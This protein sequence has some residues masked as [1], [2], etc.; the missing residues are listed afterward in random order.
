MSRIVDAVNAPFAPV[1]AYFR[2]H[3]SFGI[4]VGV[5]LLSIA[6]PLLTRVPPFDGI[7]S[8]NAWVNA[9]TTAAIYAMLAMGLNVVIGF[10]GLLE[11]EAI[12]PHV[13]GR[14]GDMLLA[15]ERHPAMLLY[16]DQ[17][18]SIGP[19]SPLGQLGLGQAG[20]RAVFLQA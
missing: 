9:F 12:R 15:V 7:Q 2:K 4:F 6:L 17:A 3:R 13:T 18:Q 11:M 5:A 10:A 20:G 1:R 19:G 16:L 8:T 14:F